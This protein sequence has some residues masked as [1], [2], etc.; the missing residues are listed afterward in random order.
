MA[1]ENFAPH[2]GTVKEFSNEFL[3]N[4]FVFPQ[5]KNYL[6]IF[7]DLCG[8]RHNIYEKLNGLWL[9]GK[10]ATLIN[11]IERRITAVRCDICNNHLTYC[12]TKK[13]HWWECKKC[14][15]I[16]EKQKRK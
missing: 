13:E 15:M 10:C 9:C 1:L 5:R 16:T 14:K 4:N 7:C 3:K 8:T 11:N 2:T 12:Q 6:W